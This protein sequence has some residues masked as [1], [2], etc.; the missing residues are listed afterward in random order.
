MKI[1][2]AINFIYVIDVQLNLNKSI[3]YTRTRGLR[4]IRK[5]CERIV[6]SHS[7]D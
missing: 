2:K 1:L 7:F 3:K 6:L 5:Q 4:S